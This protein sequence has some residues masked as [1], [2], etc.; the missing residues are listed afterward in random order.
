[1]V[2]EEKDGICH[3]FY[4]WVG[5]DLV[6][7]WCMPGNGGVRTFLVTTRTT[8]GNPIVEGFETLCTDIIK[9]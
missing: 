9:G 6:Y 8:S 2:K 4:T 1:M 3:K 7:T 5:E